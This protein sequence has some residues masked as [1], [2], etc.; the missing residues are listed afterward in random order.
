MVTDVIV[1]SLSYIFSLIIRFQYMFGKTSVDMYDMP[2]IILSIM[3]GIAIIFVFYLLHMY[4][5]YRFTS[6][7]NEVVTIVLVNGVCMLFL[8][9]FL[10]ITKSIDFSRAV[11]LIWWG[12]SCV[13]LIAK[14]VVFRATIGHVYQSKQTKNIAVVGNGHLA[15]QYMENITKN[16]KQKNTVI[17]GYISAVEKEGLGVCL[18]SYEDL[19]RIIEEQEID[20]LIKERLEYKNVRNYE[21]ADEIK[22]SILE[23]GIM[24]KDSREGT[25]WDIMIN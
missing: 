1:I 14:R 6:Y 16:P 11:L 20:E 17:K 2:Y 10:F 7:T 4:G 18:G 3:Y 5:T 25:T 24:I 8:M 21:K 15:H 12:L 22:Q 13:L 19:E 9:A 23:K